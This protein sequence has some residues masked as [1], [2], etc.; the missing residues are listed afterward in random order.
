MA[1]NIPD[2]IHIPL[3]TEGI[4]AFCQQWGIVE[5]ALFGSVLRDDF[6][7]QSDVDVLVQFRDDV[8]YSLRDL[9]QMGDELE[10]LFGRSVDLIDRQAI[11]ESLNYI[12]REII[13]NSRQVIY[14]DAHVVA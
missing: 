12:R 1:L 3:P 13:L 5:F 4:R 11:E 6:T 8:E 9:I 7:P 10:V 14:A 2:S